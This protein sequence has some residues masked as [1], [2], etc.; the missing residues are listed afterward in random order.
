MTEFELDSLLDRM[1]R[2]EKYIEAQ[3]LAAEK[4]ARIAQ[5][6]SPRPRI[7]AYRFRPKCDAT[8]SRSGV[9]FAFQCALQEAN[10]ANAELVTALWEISE[11]HL[12]LDAA[13][14]ERIA[15]AVLAKVKP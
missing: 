15:S 2:V 4:A 7:E 1:N 6:K 13:G 8:T 9:E 11:N 12:L 10:A 3:R 5:A 14:L